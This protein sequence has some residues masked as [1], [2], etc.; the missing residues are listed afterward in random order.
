MA[1]LYKMVYSDDKL[2]VLRNNPNGE[3]LRSI[4]LNTLFLTVRNL[5]YLKYYRLISLYYNTLIEWAVKQKLNIIIEVTGSG[6]T[7][8]NVYDVIG[9]D[10]KVM[11]ENARSLYKKYI[12]AI[13]VNIWDEYINVIYRSL[14]Q[15]RYIKRPELVR[16][17]NESFNN[18]V[19]IL[20]NPT[21]NDVNIDLYDNTDVGKSIHLMERKTNQKINCIAHP[22]KIDK[23]EVGFSKLLNVCPTVGGGYDLPYALILV[24]LILLYMMY[25]FLIVRNESNMELNPG[26]LTSSTINSGI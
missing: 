15:Y 19:T 3:K 24:L 18:L 11:D 5:V 1:R 2:D 21:Y 7:P 25:H 22:D 4:L 12:K 17:A 8:E 20:N 23:I 26:S 16:S 14:S 10:S 6:N 13:H 9:P